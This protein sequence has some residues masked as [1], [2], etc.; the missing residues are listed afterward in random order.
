MAKRTRYTP[1]LIGNYFKVAIR[2]LLKHKAYSFINISGLALGTACCILVL[3][4]VQNEWRYDKH[5]TNAGQIYRIVS[6]RINKQNGQS[7]YFEYAAYR[8]APALK[9][10]FPENNL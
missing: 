9:A 7:E 4:F 1:I 2:N 10:N 5:H 6:E 8:L 3:L